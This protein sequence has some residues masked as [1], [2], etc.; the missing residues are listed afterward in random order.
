MLTWRTATL[1]DRPTGHLYV[2]DRLAGFFGRPRA[3]VSAGARLCALVAWTRRRHK[4]N[5]ALGKVA[6]RTTQN[7]TPFK[8][9][10][11]LTSS[12]RGS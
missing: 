12:T 9:S 11:E 8:L 7:I 3:S 10:L 6:A 1:V 5:Q 4:P 2:A